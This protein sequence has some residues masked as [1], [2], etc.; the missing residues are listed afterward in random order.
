MLL[1]NK[2]ELRPNSPWFGNIKVPNMAP[3]AL[4]EGLATPPLGMSDPAFMG[5]AAFA[6]LTALAILGI[7]STRRANGGTGRAIR[8][9]A[10][11]G[12]AGCLQPDERSGAGALS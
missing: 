10:K 11:P 4:F 8:T 9:R 7:H 3:W 12:T 6:A 5:L 2:G 1:P